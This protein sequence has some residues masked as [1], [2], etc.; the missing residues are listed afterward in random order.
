MAARHAEEDV[1]E[2]PAL[3]DLVQIGQEDGHDHARLDPLAEE[4]DEGRNHRR[5]S[6]GSYIVQILGKPNFLV[7][8]P[9]DARP[10]PPLRRL[11]DDH[12]AQGDQP[13]VGTEVVDGHPDQ[14]APGGPPSTWH[15]ASTGP[16]RTGRR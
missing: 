16:T 10:V 6:E 14:V 1:P 13:V 9:S 2:V 5:A 7:C 4:D 11:E 12:R 15:R 3:A 8:Q